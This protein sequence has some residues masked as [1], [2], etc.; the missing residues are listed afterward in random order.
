ML[1]NRISSMFR[2]NETGLLPRENNG[3][4]FYECIIFMDGEF[5]VSYNK[6]YPILYCL[7][8]ERKNYQEQI[9][10]TEYLKR[11]SCEFKYYKG[12]RHI[13]FMDHGCIVDDSPLTS[14]EPYFNGTKDECLEFYQ[15]LRKDIL[16]FLH[17][18]GVK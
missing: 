4:K 17:K 15:E 16:H 6:N 9:G 7:S 18:N 11:Q 2:H 3:E 14:E 12:S 10:T 5:P 8:E 1:I 13:S